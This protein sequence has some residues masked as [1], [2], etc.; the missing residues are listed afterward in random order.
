MREGGRN[1]SPLDSAKQQTL[2]E[3]LEGSPLRG[4]PLR[5]RLRNF[6]PAADT[7]IASL[8]GP[9]PYMQRLREIEIRL[10]QHQRQLQTA[11]D[12]LHTES[13]NEPSFGRRWLEPADRWRFDEVNDLIDH[14]NRYFPAE[15]RLP[16]IRERATSCSSRASATSARRSTPRGSSNGFRLS[17][18]PP[19]S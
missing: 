2:A 10:E 15:A 12:E 19:R 16:M 13:G 4:E 11:W 7:Y 18:T 8:G 17:P 14:H 9:R 5:R 6:R 3:D 1:D